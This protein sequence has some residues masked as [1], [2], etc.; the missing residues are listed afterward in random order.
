MENDTGMNSL[1][2][3]LGD[4]E[5]EEPEF[6]D[7][8]TEEVVIYNKA[9]TPEEVIECMYEG[10]ETHG[11]KIVNNNLVTSSYSKDE[12]IEMTKA[13]DFE[14][15]YAQE[16]NQVPPSVAPQPDWRLQYLEVKFGK[17][18]V[19][20][21]LYPTATWLRIL[22]KHFEEIQEKVNATIEDIRN[23]IERLERR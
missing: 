4:W 21:P 22:L 3:S 23:E 8:Q 12:L 13:T 16:Y 18:E 17:R 6:I 20:M 10:P 2:R 9:L 11:Q 7:F 5:E 1:M 14:E 15:I 19:K